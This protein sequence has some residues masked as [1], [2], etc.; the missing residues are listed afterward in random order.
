MHL[1]SVYFALWQT[2]QAQNRQETLKLFLNKYYAW[3]S[4]L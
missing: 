3:Y 4:T 1:F 2:D